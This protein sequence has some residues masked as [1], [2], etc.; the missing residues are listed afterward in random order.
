MDITDIHQYCTLLPGAT[1]DQ[2]FGDDCVLYRIENHIFAC[3]MIERFEHPLT[4]KLAPEYGI[5]V[6]ERYYDVVNPAWHWNKKYWS[7]IDINRLPEKVIK[8][9]ICHSYNEVLKKLPKK[10]QARIPMLPEGL[11]PC[12][13]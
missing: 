10:V 4:V 8:H 12:E 11:Q 3:I 2:A 6:R 1:C 5:E 9:L 7:E 13:D